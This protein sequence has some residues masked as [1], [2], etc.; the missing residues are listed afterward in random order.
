MKRVAVFGKKYSAED[1]KDLQRL[2]KKLELE[3]IEVLIFEDFRKMI[4][5]AVKLPDNFET[6]SKHE[7]LIKNIDML[8][9]IGGDGTLLDSITLIR[10]SEIPVIGINMGRLGFLTG[11]SRNNI[12]EAIDALIIGE[13]T[14]DKR[15][16]LH[17]DTP[18]NQFGELNFAL[19]EVTIHQ[20]E[21]PSLISIDVYAD[22]V[23][24]NSYWAD[25]LIVS[26]PTGSTGYSLSC[27]GPI[28]VPGARNF[29]ITP[30]ATH[31]LTVRPIVISDTVEIRLKAEGRGKMIIGLDARFQ[32]F[33]A[34]EEIVVRKEDFFVNL[35]KLKNKNFYSTIR[36]K[37][38]W[39]L[40]TRN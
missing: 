40:D 10:D 34:S 9:S 8:F 29:V 32:P 18:K 33:N 37:L 31:N 12:E 27:G 13:Y 1:Q 17:L 16:L 26:T 36:E 7:E 22:G 35:V 15:S 14:L 19:N 4:G 39:G 20:R 11:I 6:F 25:G 24:V 3:K 5:D 28:M 2:F 30:I 21:T 23:F 38:N